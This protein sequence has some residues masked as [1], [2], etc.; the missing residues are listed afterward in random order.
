MPNYCD[1]NLRVKGKSLDIA[2]FVRDCIS[3]DIKQYPY[4]NEIYEDKFLDFNRIVPEPENNE[5]HNWYSWR[6]ENWGT[7]WEV[8]ETHSFR[9][10]P[11]DKNNEENREIE[12]TILFSTAWTPANKIY[13][14]L[15]KKYKDTSL[16][17]E[18]EYYEG[19]CAFAGHTHFSNG[20]ITEDYY[21]EYKQGDNENNIKYY[22]YLME[23][24]HESIEWLSEELECEMDMNDEKDEVI[25]ETVSRFEEYYRRNRFLAAASIYVEHTKASYSEV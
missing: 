21:V 14:A 7:K 1:N 11:V 19:G 5:N 24:E 18:I 25:E 20:Q 23:K 13:E 10:E 2:E 17:F 8:C 16:E 15:M 3:L 6:L 12:L 9:I 22:A 4:S